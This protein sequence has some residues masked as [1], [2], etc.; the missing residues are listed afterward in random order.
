MIEWFVMREIERRKKFEAA[1]WLLSSLL[2]FQKTRLFGN[3][4]VKTPHFGV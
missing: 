1:L 3:L 2:L 4:S